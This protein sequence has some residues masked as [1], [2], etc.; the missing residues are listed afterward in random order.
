MLYASFPFYTSVAPQPETMYR[1]L[2]ISV[3]D[4][5][6]F[7]EA[8]TGVVHTKSADDSGCENLLPLTGFVFHSAHCGSTLLS[9]MFSHSGAVRTINETDAINGLLLS[10]HLHDLDEDGVIHLLQK[11]VSEYLVLPGSCRHAVFKLSSWN[12]FF[13][14]LFQKA[15]PKVPWIYLHREEDALISS[16]LRS[17]KGFVTWYDLPADL[18]VRAFIPREIPLATK[19]DYLRQMS[20]M[21]MDIALRHQAQ[22]GLL[23]RYPDFL[24]EFSTSILPHFGIALNDTEAAAAMDMLRYDAKSGEPLSNL[25]KD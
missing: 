18:M 25:A 17:G 12:V 4:A 10:Y 22:D 5:P 15:F 19:E 16:L 20:R 7:N 9:R 11:I 2:P 13:L 23:L 8:P 14:P 1:I 24:E 6:F 3:F 21:Q